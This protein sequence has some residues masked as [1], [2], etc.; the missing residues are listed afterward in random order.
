MKTHWLYSKKEREVGWVEEHPGDELVFSD[1]TFKIA[2]G[3]VVGVNPDKDPEG[4]IDALKEHVLHQEG[5][6]LETTESE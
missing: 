5:L 3:V 4:F 1:D 6:R 2:T